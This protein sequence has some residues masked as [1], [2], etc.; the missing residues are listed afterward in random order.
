MSLRWDDET[1]NKPMKVLKDQIRIIAKDPE[2]SENY[3]L[4]LKRAIT[5]PPRHTVVVIGWVLR[6]P[7]Y[8]VGELNVV[9]ERLFIKPMLWGNWLYIL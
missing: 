8:T 3:M 5:V 9:N 4:R 7:A 6:G 2:P 1:N